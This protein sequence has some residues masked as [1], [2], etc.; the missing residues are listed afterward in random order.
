[1][2]KKLT[3]N[4]KTERL[5]W[6]RRFRQLLNNVA[7]E[8]SITA[9]ELSRQIEKKLPTVHKQRAPSGSI[10]NFWRSGTDV[11]VEQDHPDIRVP[12]DQPILIAL[13][14]VLTDLGAL[15]EIPKHQLKGECISFFGRLGFSPPD[16]L[17]AELS[18]RPL[19]EVIKTIRKRP[20]NAAVTE[21]DRHRDL[22]ALISSLQKG[23]AMF[24]IGF[25]KP[26]RAVESE[27]DLRQA[28]LA[29]A[30]Y[31]GSEGM[32]YFIRPGPTVFGEH[33]GEP[34]NDESLRYWKHLEIS[35]QSWVT[36]NDEFERFRRYSSEL[37]LESI[38]FVGT[39]ADW[40]KKINDIMGHL[41][42]V[43]SRLLTPFMTP[44]HVY[45]LFCSKEPYFLLY[46]FELVPTV[47]EGRSTSI[48]RPLT[49]SVT[50]Q[51]AFVILSIFESAET[52]SEV[53][54]NYEPLDSGIKLLKSAL[55]LSSD[56]NKT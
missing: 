38:D 43:G 56:I 17:A 45:A 27:S 53:V 34:S 49:D 5:E 44:G 36:I 21:D 2:P 8:R 7:D 52:V 28:T 41:I 9:E 33:G 19:F 40:N 10:I 14:Q 50:Q 51:L 48:H 35:K 22:V 6:K 25:D 24:H 20:L 39:P 47:S 54:E 11:D 26:A 37:Y 16:T 3:S 13:W 23:D 15:D 30:D 29:S 42:L 1:M 18:A 55:R 31:E 32:F 4:E 46:S 12:N